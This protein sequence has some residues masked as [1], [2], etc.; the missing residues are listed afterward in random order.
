[1]KVRN[2]PRADGRKQQLATP[3]NFYLIVERIRCALTESALFFG[4]LDRV[5]FFP[6]HAESRKEQPNL[7][8]EDDVFDSS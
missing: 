8:T 7:K 6:A 4:R 5:F 1:M 2:R 3:T